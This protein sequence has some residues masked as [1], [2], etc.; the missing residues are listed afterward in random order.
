MITLRELNPRGYP[1]TDEIAAN[2]ETLLIR[3]NDVRANYGL[4]MIVT[5]GLRSAEDQARINPNASKSR[6]LTG[7]AVDIHDPRKRLQAWVWENVELVA[8]I[9]LWMESFSATPTWVHFQIVP[10]KSGKRFFLP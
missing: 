10:P 6:H 3:M 9:G 2:L 4:P 1:T 5:S 7:E 8:D